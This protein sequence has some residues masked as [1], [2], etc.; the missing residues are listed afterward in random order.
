MRYFIKTHMIC[1]ILS[2]YMD[3][4]PRWNFDLGYLVSAVVEHEIPL[5]S[6]GLVCIVVSCFKSSIFENFTEY[7]FIYLLWNSNSD[8]CV[9]VCVKLSGTSILQKFPCFWFKNKC[10]YP[11][12]GTQLGR[13]HFCWIRI[14]LSPYWPWM[15]SASP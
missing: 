1:N 10:P 2:S 12:L 9:R 11:C 8:V 15:P 6:F 13:S 4:L 5:C 14:Q 3:L 7:F